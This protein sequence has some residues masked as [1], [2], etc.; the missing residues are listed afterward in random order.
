MIGEFV[1]LDELQPG[2]IFGDRTR[3][4]RWRGI[5][6]QIAVAERIYLGYADVLDEEGCESSYPLASP[7]LVWEDLYV[8]E[9][10]R[11]DRAVPTVTLRD[12]VIVHPDRIEVVP[13]MELVKRRSREEW[14]RTHPDMPWQDSGSPNK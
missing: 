1:R 14:D 5:V 4:Q 3:G 6:I 8:V 2:L 10:A 9:A 7:L 13:S 12:C 11:L